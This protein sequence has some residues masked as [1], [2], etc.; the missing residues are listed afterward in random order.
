MAEQQTLPESDN[1]SK[2]E[3]VE[4]LLAQAM[5]YG[6]HTACCAMNLPWMPNVCGCGWNAMKE[7]VSRFKNNSPAAGDNGGEELTDYYG[8]TR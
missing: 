4:R 1:R 2:V 3:P 5:S 6:R 8:Q 7:R